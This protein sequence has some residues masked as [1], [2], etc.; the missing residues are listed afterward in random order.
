LVDCRPR[1]LGHLR[2]DV[3]RSSQQWR[4]RRLELFA[5]VE[6]LGLGEGGVE[7]G[8]EPVGL[9]AQQSH[10]GSELGL[11]IGARRSPAGG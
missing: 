11:P 9:E 4:Q 8:L 2:R 7:V 1:E 10:R 6:V 3:E 5:L